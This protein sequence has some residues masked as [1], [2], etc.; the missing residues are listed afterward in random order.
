[1][2]IAFIGAGNMGA[3]MAL[4]LVRAG[5]ELTVYNRTREKLQPLAQAG[6]RIANTPADAV[7]AAEVAIT[8]LADDRAVHDVI[9]ESHAIGALAPGAIHMSASTISVALSKELAQAHRAKNQGYV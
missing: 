1:M 8:M 3:P 7:H 2:K 9:F 6:A 4:N 5:H